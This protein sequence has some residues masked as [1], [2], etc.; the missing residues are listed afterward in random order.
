MA[1]EE[2]FIMLITASFGLVCNL[3]MV[4]ILHS[5]PGGHIHLPE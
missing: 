5:S 4:K 3:A 1:V 2:P